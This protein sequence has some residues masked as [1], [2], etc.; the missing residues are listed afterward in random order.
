MVLGKLS[1][2][3]GQAVFIDWIQC[4]HHWGLW[5]ASIYHVFQS[6]NIN[7]KNM[8]Y[9][10]LD[11]FCFSWDAKYISEPFKNNNNE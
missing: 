6:N 5:E 9:T 8:F 3:C 4:M 7:N 2:E 10:A 11:W 1:I